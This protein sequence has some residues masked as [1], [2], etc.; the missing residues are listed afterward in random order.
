LLVC[1]S[2]S[3]VVGHVAPLSLDSHHLYM[4]G[5]LP[6]DDGVAVHV[7]AV[8]AGC[9]AARSAVSVADSAGA[10]TVKA[11]PLL[12]RPFTVTV[13]GPVVAPL[14][15]TATMFVLLQLDIVA[16]VPLNATVL[17]AAPKYVPAIVTLAPTGADDGVRLDI[18][19]AVLATIAYGALVQ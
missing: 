5:P 6:P 1:Q 10:V 15:T 18:A 7:I 8:P 4:K 17:S 2:V 19:G 3:G 13:S 12:T 11:T 16:V 14:G 9:G